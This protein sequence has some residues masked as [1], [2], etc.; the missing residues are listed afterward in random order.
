MGPQ[1]IEANYTWEKIAR[2]YD[3]LF[4]KLRLDDRAH[5]PRLRPGGSTLEGHSGEGGSI[6]PHRCA[7]DTRAPLAATAPKFCGDQEHPRDGALAH[8]R[9]GSRHSCAP[10]TSIEV[11]LRLVSSARK[12]HADELLKHSGL[13]DD[14]IVST[15][16]GPPDP[17]YSLARY[18]R[19][20]IHGLIGELRSRNSI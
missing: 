9:R 11:T 14:V 19:D 8:R 10:R 5:S 12:Q 2:Q 18:D 16:R 15:F 3:E 7:V 6:P 4:A 17:E 1:R 13:V 20:A